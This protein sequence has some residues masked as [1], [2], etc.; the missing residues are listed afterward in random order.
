MVTHS[1]PKP[2]RLI[3]LN[4]QRF[5]ADALLP[6]QPSSAVGRIL[7]VDD[8]QLNHAILSRL[9]RQRGF[10]VVEAESG[11]RAIAVVAEQDLDLVLLDIVMPEMDGFAVLN[12]LRKELTQSD[13]P[14]IMVTASA[15]SEQVVRAFESGAN[16]YI[17]KPV[18]VAV[19][20]A[21]INTHVKLK[22]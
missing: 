10:S 21:R 18:D 16:D 4:Q 15:E 5:S 12:I 3:S 13:L 11:A 22:A 7:V 1:Y 9:L 14:V 19:T 17:T 2:A 6:S 8:E 20:M